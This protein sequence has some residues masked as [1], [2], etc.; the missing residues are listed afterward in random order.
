MRFFLVF[1]VVEGFRS[2]VIRAN[3]AN[4]VRARSSANVA[5]LV[6]MLGSLNG[7]IDVSHNIFLLTESSPARAR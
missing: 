2:N 4:R 3:F 6:G 5:H 7:L 1:F